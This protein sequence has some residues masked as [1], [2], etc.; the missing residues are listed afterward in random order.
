MDNKILTY[1]ENQQKTVWMK[2]DLEKHYDAVL[3]WT[4]TYNLDS[5]Y[6]YVPVWRVQFGACQFDVTHFDVPPQSSFMSAAN[7]TQQ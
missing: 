2:Q 7:G 4:W 3:A 5:Q 1:K 6:D